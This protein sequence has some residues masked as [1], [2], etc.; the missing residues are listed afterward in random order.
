MPVWSSPMKRLP[1]GPT[2]M[3]VGRAIGAVGVLESADELFPLRASDRSSSTGV[4]GS[5]PFIGDEDD[6]RRDRRLMPGAVQRDERAAAIGFR[7]RMRAGRVLADR[8]RRRSASRTRG[9]RRAATAR[10]RSRGRRRRGGSRSSRASRS[11]RRPDGA[12]R[13]R[14]SRRDGRA[15]ARP[16]RRRRPTACPVAGFVA[17]AIA[18]RMWRAFGVMPLPS[19]SIC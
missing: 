9:R 19:S 18:L 12:S 13:H 17:S 3:P 6:A 16:V 10:S 7:K 14:R 8:T 11:R 4:F 15:R 1:S 2:A 5:S